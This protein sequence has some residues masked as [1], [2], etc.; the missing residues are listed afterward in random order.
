MVSQIHQQSS[1]Q[2]PISQSD[3]QTLLRIRRHTCAHIM[4]MAVQNLFPETKVTIGP[5]T[6]TGFYYDFDRTQPFTPEDLSQIEAEMR[7]IVGANLPIVREEVS[8]EEMRT[9]IEEL[10]EP[11]KLEILESIPTDEP[12]TRYYIGF[13]DS[14]PVTEG[15][16]SLFKSV[17]PQAK[18]K[19]HDYWWDLCEGPHVTFTGEINPNAFALES[20]EKALIGAVTKIILSCNGFMEQQLKIIGVKLILME[21]MSYF[22]RLIWLVW[23]YGKH[24]DTLISIRTICSSR[25][26]LKRSNIK[27][28]P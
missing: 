13:P 12:V 16:P 25:W 19:N 4:A 1:V 23:G 5:W 8:R 27:L 15:E 2:E 10:G 21:D 11:Y 28:N 14:V 17:P 6:E 9:E 26:K 20:V 7:R 18:P 24:L 3:P 22:T